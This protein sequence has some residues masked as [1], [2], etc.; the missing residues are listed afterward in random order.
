MFNAEMLKSKVGNLWAT[1]PSV[2]SSQ[3]MPMRVS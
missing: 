3:Q 2:R 1:R